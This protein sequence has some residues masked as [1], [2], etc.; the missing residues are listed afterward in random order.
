MADDKDQQ[1]Q[2]Q[3]GPPN[4]PNLV[5]VNLLKTL[6]LNPKADIPIFYGDDTKGHSYSM[7]D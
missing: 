4:P 3:A 7:F 1:A 6:F 2:P 5:N